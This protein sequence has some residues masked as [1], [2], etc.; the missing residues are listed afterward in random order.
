MKLVHLL[1]EQALLEVR[2][3]RAAIAA[4]ETADCSKRL[5]KA[6]NILRELEGESGHPA[7]LAVLYEYMQRRL[8]EALISLRD[9][10]I[11]EVE[12][13]IG[14]LHEGWTAMAHP[15]PS[16]ASVAIYAELSPH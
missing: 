11:A 10:P 7:N 14:T 6:L 3:A 8:T 4:G 1:Y 13:L 5:T 16:S 9:E 15:H 2:A 12:S